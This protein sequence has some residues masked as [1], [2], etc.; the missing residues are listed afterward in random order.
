[1]GHLRDASSWHQESPAAIALPDTQEIALRAAIEA[2]Y[3]DPP[4]ETTL[5][6][7]AADLD[8]PRSTLSYRLRQA[9]ST[10]LHQYIEDTEATRWLE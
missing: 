8:V 9:E 1:M 2:G 7:I 4:R 3:Y 6:E 5:D 10:L